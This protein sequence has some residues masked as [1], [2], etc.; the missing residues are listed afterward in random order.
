MS[1]ICTIFMSHLIKIHCIPFKCLVCLLTSRQTI[2]TYQYLLRHLLSISSMT[3]GRA[4]T[5]MA[6]CWQHLAE[7]CV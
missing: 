6:S 5:P 4:T 1:V 3:L 2:T 7:P